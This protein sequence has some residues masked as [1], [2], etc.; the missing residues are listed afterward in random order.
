[1]QKKISTQTK[2]MFVGALVISFVVG[3]FSGSSIDPRNSQTL[4]KNREDVIL[5]CMRACP[6]GPG[7]NACGLACFN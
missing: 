6:S 2:W 3:F 5:T 1:M 4:L 7:Q